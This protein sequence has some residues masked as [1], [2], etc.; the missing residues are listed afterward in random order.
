MTGSFFFDKRPAVNMGIVLA[1]SLAAFQ[2]AASPNPM[3]STSL[4]DVRCYYLGGPNLCIPRQ[5]HG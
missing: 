1:C 3:V 4:D 5:Q 2:A